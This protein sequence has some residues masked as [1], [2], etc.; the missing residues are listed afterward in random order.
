MAV[1]FEEVN[2]HLENV[3]LSSYEKDGKNFFSPEAA[4]RAPGEVL[5]KVCGIYKIARPILALVSALPLIP[6]KWK[7]VL[8]TFIGLMDSLCP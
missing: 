6:Q 3:D 2:K 5:S 8:K 7:D 4:L 1:T